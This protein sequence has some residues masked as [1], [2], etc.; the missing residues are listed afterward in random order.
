MSGLRKRPWDSLSVA[1]QRRL[2]RAGIGQASYESGA[3]LAAARGHA[4]TP[5]HPERA[6]KRPELFPG[7]LTR[8][9]QRALRMVWR[10]TRADG[11][12]PLADR[13]ILV[14]ELSKADR[15][16]LGSYNNA[17]RNYL[18]GAPNHVAD[19]GGRT[20]RGRRVLSNGTLGEV[21]RFELEGSG[22]VLD[23]LAVVTDGLRFETLYEV[24]A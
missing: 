13:F 14:T 12:V 1:Y 16:T 9:G 11:L 10:P 24:V 23:D 17:L 15:S 18:N 5:E 4:A 6:V 2:L 22:D 19:Y 7:Y 20:I 21:R 3:S 8:K